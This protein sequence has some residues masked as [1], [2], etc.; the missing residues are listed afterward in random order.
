MQL[1]TLDGRSNVTTTRTNA[2]TH[3]YECQPGSMSYVCVTR[4][5]LRSAHVNKEEENVYELGARSSY[6]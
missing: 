5:C 1:V 4:A 2:T 6:T 3:N